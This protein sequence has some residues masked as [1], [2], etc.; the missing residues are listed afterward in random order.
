MKL[1]KII[2]IQI[3]NLVSKTWRIRIDGNFPSKPAIIVFWHGL[4]LPGWKIFSDHQPIAVVSLSKDGQILSDLLKKWNFSLIRG[5]S[6]RNGKEVLNEIIENTNNNFILMTPDGPTGP[7]TK[8]KA[9]AAVAAMR[10][11]APIV[12]CGIVIKNKFTFQKS[13]DKFELP[14]PFSNVLIRFSLPEIIPVSSSRDLI[15]AKI[16]E[17]GNKLCNLS[18]V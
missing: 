12:L 18:E 5:S 10:S 1:S 16:I 13:W 2:L 7:S 17:F 15:D 8:F 9:G 3:L 6:S 11:Q 4:M 14:L